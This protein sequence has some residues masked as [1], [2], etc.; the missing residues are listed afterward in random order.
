MPNRLQ[1]DLRQT[2]PFSSLEQEAHLSVQRTEAVLGHAVAEMLKPFDITPTQYN[3]LRIL[4]GAGEEGLCRN[5]VRDRMVAK[6]PD[7]TRLLD[8]MEAAG[9]V[10]RERGGSDRRY[11]TTRITAQGLRLVDSLDEPV[12]ALHR[13][14]LGHMDELELRTL[15]DLLARAREEG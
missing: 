14:M 7:V 13:R 11:V 9:L 4:R 12:A 10:Q 8:R 5:D 6:V 15:I 3:V 1:D 2:R